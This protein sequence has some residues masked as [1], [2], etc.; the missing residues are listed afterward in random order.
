L[1][2]KGTDNRVFSGSWVGGIGKDKMHFHRRLYT[3]VGV[4][5][6][7][8]EMELRQ[9]VV[10]VVNGNGGTA[11][12]GG[13]QLDGMTVVFTGEVESTAGTEA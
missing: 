7:C 3:R 1:V 8:V 11:G 13:I 2:D 9:G 10:G 5:T 4:F 6:A 12:G